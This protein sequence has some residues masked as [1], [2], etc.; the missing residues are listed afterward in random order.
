MSEPIHRIHKLRP[1]TV[2]WRP[3]EGE[4][5]A[6]DLR[7]SVYFAINRTG[8]LIWPELAC[9]ATREALV[10]RL[11]QTCEIDR[12]QA[13]EEV[14]EFVAALAELDLLES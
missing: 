4:V 9:G 11:A 10:A 2:E 14:D 12:R 5:V 13:G 8:A 6:V 7:T 3:I 1:N